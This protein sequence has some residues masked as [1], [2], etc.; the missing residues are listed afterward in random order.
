MARHASRLRLH[1]LA[2]HFP[3][4]HG[5]RALA[6][7]SVLQVHVSI[8]FDWA[9]LL[10]SPTLL[11]R[12]TSVWFGMD[13]F[14][15][16]SGFLIGTLLLPGPDGRPREGVGRFYA[17]R[18]FRIIPLYYV[19][20]SVLAFGDSTLP[21]QR[22][23]VLFEYAYLS[24]YPLFTAPLVM[25]WAW[26]L[27]V[28]EHF[29]LAV[30]ILALLLARLPTTAWRIAALVAL[31]VLG[32]AVRYAVY[33]TH[34]TP[35]DR[36]ELFQLLYLRTHTRFDILVAG[37]LLAYVQGSYAPQLRAA[38]RGRPIRVV[39][40]IVPAVCCWALLGPL[41]ARHDL[42]SVFAWGTI[43][44]MMYFSLILLLLN[45]ETSVARWL[46][47]RYFLRF[48]TLGYGIYLV[49]PPLIAHVI[50]PAAYFMIVRCR[51]PIA[52]VWPCA[53]ALLL[54]VASLVAYLLHIAVEKPALWVRDLA[55]RQEPASKSAAV[56]AG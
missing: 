13:L 56:A 29:Y 43:T 5:L 51:L 32:F 40:A 10:Q 2:N 24:N 38:L 36:Q 35:W 30:P 52:V 18:A 53:L 8:T 17:R 55:T 49:H 39:L 22:H 11:A 50:L 45:T 37:V 48:A 1:L 25:P 26:S 12:S 19:V 44:S 47:S 54:V 46:S 15:I 28:E 42:S 27:C 16:L 31:W 3:P 20:L 9:G 6:I 34:A 23:G 41:A 7:V 4:L 14:F 33:T 21:A